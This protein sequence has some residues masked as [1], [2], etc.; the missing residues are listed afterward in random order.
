MG[1][2]LKKVE[3]RGER[4][5]SVSCLYSFPTI[6]VALCVWHGDCSVCPRLLEAAFGRQVG[7][8][9]ERRMGT[10]K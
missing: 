6:D 1:G 5:T 2:G 10:R 4:R 7:P 9:P 3:P 8:D